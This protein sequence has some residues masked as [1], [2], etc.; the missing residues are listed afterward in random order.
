MLVDRCRRT[1]HDTFRRCPFEYGPLVAGRTGAL[2]HTC[3][4]RI[5]R[6]LFFF[7]FFDFSE[8]FLHLYKEL[9]IRVRD[10]FVCATAIVFCHRVFTRRNFFDGD[11]LTIAVACLF[12]ACKVEETPRKVKDTVMAAHKVRHQ[13]QHDEAAKAPYLGKDSPAFEKL[14]AGLLAAE[15]D[16]LKHLCF[17]FE[18]EHPHRHLVPTLHALGLIDASLR[19]R[20]LAIIND[21]YFTS[22]CLTHCP[23]TI[24]CGALYYAAKLIRSH[25]LPDTSS[26]V[27]RFHI[28]TGDMTTMS[29]IMDEFYAN[30]ATLF[31]YKTSDYD[32]LLAKYRVPPP[33]PRYIPAPKPGHLP[34]RPPVVSENPP[35]LQ[36]RHRFVSYR[37]PP[38][39]P[40]P[41]RSSSMSGNREHNHDQQS[42][43]RRHAVPQ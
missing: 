37:A 19:E 39:P 29:A 23:R 34:A 40:P 13:L 10:S 12:L 25:S 11:R 2:D 30:K 20:A 3:L 1:Q 4:Q 18:V 21:M 6:F 26:W 41:P 43:R 7:F 31:Q 24:A 22:L 14:R 15:F 28:A 27:E 33:P 42:D 17:D 38:P 5:I 35:S 16:V 32:T 8:N 9:T 36:E